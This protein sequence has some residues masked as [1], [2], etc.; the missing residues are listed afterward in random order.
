M[1]AKILPFPRKGDQPD[2]NEVRLIA[3]PEAADPYTFFMNVM[4]SLI[5]EVER[6]RGRKGLKWL[7]TVLTRQIEYVRGRLQ[8]QP[9]KTGENNE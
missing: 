3:V 1:T 8:S 5:V 7:D 2:P 6:L 4:R 9:D